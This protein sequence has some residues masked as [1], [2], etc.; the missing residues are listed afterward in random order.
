MPTGINPYARPVNAENGEAP[1]PSGEFQLGGPG[2]Y[3]VAD[4]PETTDPEYRDGYSPVLKAGGSPDG[5]NLPDDIRTQRREPP[6]NDPN[7]REYWRIRR[8]EFLERH[9]VENY[10]TGWDVQQYKVP[11][12]QNPLWTQER[13]PIRPTADNSPLNYTMSRPWHI[14]RNIKD[15]VGEHAVTHFSLADHRRLYEIYGMQPQGETGVN[16]YRHDTRP[17]DNNL[18]PPATGSSM[19]V[20]GHHGY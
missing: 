12:G 5:T 13:L 17:W 6:P 3:S 20:W 19:S 1:D 9:S 7:Q 16:T 18:Y 14:P 15:A 4:I 8:S 10:N 11:P 2:V